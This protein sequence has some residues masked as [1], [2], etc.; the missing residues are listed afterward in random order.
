MRIVRIDGER[1]CSIPTGGA[2][3]LP[4]R[5]DVT[6]LGATAAF[7]DAGRVQLRG[8]GDVVIVSSS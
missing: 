1:D 2:I 5:G 3:L 7:A 8:N 4:A 6:S